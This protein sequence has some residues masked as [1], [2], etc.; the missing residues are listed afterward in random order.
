[1]AKTSFLMLIIVVI[2]SVTPTIN[3]FYLFFT[4]KIA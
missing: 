3:F 1:M 2:W 4:L